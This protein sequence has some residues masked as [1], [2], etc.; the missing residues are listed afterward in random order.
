MDNRFEAF[1]TSHLLM[2]AIFVV[3]IP[4]LVR[5]GRRV[6]GT[7]AEDRSRRVFAVAIVA[8]AVPLQVLQLLPGDWDFAT[9]L[10]LQLCDLAWMA[11]AYALWTRRPWACAL[12]YFWGLTLTSQALVT[13]GL[14][15]DFPHPRFIGFWAMHLL[16]VW[17]AVHL[18]A[19]LRVRPT[20]RLY[21]ST[22]AVT[23][24]W[25]VTVM[26]FNVAFGTN[27]GYLNG[28]PGTGSLLDL[29]GPWP[30]YVVTEITLV[31]GVWA[32][33]TLPWTGVR[34]VS[35]PASTPVAA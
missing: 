33:I 14:V 35:R 22:V 26:A 10:P 21:R 6:A 17:A 23:L 13:P 31:T 18:T 1:G 8:T 19:G 28:K 12:T 29:L 34:R 25:A 30:W 5:H 2:L 24:V 27:Y 11:S 16:V 3:G 4:L 15:Q 7:P 32:L 20:W 9:S